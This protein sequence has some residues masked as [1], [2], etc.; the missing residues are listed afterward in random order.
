MMTVIPASSRKIWLIEVSLCGMGSASAPNELGV[1]RSTAGTTGGGAITASKFCTD[2]PT[3]GSTV[4]TTWSVQPTLGQ[5]VLALGVNAN[6]G[7]YRWVARPGE[8]IE[9]RQA[10]D[11]IS[12]RSATGTSAV[13]VF[14]VVIED[15]A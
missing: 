10:V 12:L 5:K 3:A 4:D 11:Q 13:S 9:F 8:E 2:A 7:I 6:G 1:Y 15:P 14:I